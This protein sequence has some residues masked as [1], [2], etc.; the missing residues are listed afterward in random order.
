MLIQDGKTLLLRRAQGRYEGGLWDIPGGT[1]EAGE[2]PAETVVREFREETGL[3]I[4][5]RSE[6][7][8]RTTMD[9]QGR[10]ILFVTI[11]FLVDLLDTAKNRVKISHEHDAFVW[12]DLHH[13][14]QFPVVPH[15]LPAVEILLQSM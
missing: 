6:F 5:V 15:V 13:V 8:R 3:R 4:R 11:T 10:L 14:A 1:V 12:V 9:T 2:C 7:T